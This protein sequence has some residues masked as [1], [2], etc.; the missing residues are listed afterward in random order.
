M[1]RDRSSWCRDCL[2]REIDC[3]CEEDEESSISAEHT[4]ES[5]EEEE[6]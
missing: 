4:D 6:N 1:K 3:G 5:S 2:A